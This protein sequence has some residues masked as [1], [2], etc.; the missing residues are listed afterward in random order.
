MDGCSSNWAGAL[1]IVYA[2]AAGWF[3]GAGVP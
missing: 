1:E 3:A 2:I